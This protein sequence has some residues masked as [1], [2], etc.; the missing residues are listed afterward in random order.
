MK[1]ITQKQLAFYK[2]Y[3]ERESNEYLPAWHFLGEVFIEELN[4]WEFMGY[5]CPTR[6]TDLFQ[7]N[8]NLL[9]RKMLTGRS[10]S[11]YYGYKFKTGATPNDIVEFK[12][13]EFYKTIKRWERE[14]AVKKQIQNE[15][16]N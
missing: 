12:V 5:K 13:K 2:L 10:G 3:K 11:Q 9:E 7:E 6:L 1:K 15:R 14:I 4:K 8:P 16:D